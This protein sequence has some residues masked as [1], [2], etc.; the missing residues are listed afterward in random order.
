MSQKRRLTYTITTVITLVRMVI[1]RLVYP[2]I[3]AQLQLLAG[4]VG[5]SFVIFIFEAIDFINFKLNQRRPYEQGVFP[6]LAMQVGLSMLVTFTLHTLILKF[7]MTRFPIPLEKLT[8]M[9]SYFVDFIIVVAVNLAYFGVYFFDQWKMKILETER[10]AKEKALSQKEHARVQ[11][12]NLKNQLNPHFLFNSLASLNSLI[13]ENQE[14]ASQFLQQLSKVYRYVLE[15]KDRELVSLQT[16]TKFIQQYLMLLK[17][18]F[19]DGFIT[20]ICIE[21]GKE[22]RHIVPIT[23]QILIENALKHNKVGEASPLRVCIRTEGD[24]L[25]V[26]NNLQKKSQV[27]SSNGMGLENMKTLYAFLSP[28]ALEVREEKDIFMVKVPLL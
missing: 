10:L 4:I 2:E 13:F 11:Y 27:D 16:E 5:W 8:I 28:T 14:L 18:R 15:N 6:R 1:L 25:I 22:G 21:P 12:D 3:S 20:D 24:F 23:L 26:S 7:F 17:T 9:I 19:G